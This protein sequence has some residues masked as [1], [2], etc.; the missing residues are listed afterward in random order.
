MSDQKPLK[1]GPTGAEQFTSTDTIPAANLPASVLL[2]GGNTTGAAVRVGTND[3]QNLTLERNNVDQVTYNS[4]GQLLQ[5]PPY[6]DSSLKETFTTTG[7]ASLSK[8]IIVCST[9]GGGF[10]L[11]LTTTANKMYYIVN[12]DSNNNLTVDPS[13]GNINGGSTITLRGNGATVWCD[14]TDWYSFR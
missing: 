7:T 14:G 13:S 11:T 10:T 3:A 6:M 4:S 8:A 1:A 9:S 2:N 5:V 12:T